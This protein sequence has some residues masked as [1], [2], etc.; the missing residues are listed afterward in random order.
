MH[1]VQLSGVA[2]NFA[3]REIFRDL[4]WEIGERDRVGLVG[5]NGSGKSSLLKVVAGVVEPDEGTVA[6]VGQVSVGYLPQDVHLPSGQSVIEAAMALPPELAALESALARVE[7]QLS[8]PAVY[9]DLGRLDQ[10]LVE[11]ERLLEEFEALGGQRHAGLVREV[12]HHLG[13][14][15]EDYDLP[16]D[17]LSGG[18]KKLVAL[19]KLAVEK[20]D[21][22][23]LDEPD[24]HLDLRAK[25]HLESFIRNYSGAVVIVSHDRYLLDEVVDRIA[26]LES[27]RLTVYPGN[28][29]TYATARELRLLRQQQLYVTQQKEV[30]RIEAMIKRFDHLA[31]VMDDERSA[32][33]ARSMR[34]R[35]DRMEA[36]GDLVDAVRERRDMKLELNGWRGSQKALEVKRLS[37]GFDDDL[38]F[39]DLDFLIQHGER[40]GLVGPN[41]RG[42]SVLMRL[43]LGELEPLDGE[44]VIGPSVRVGY[45]AQEHQTL[46]EWLDRTPLEFVRHVKVGREEDAI[47]FLIKFLFSYEQVRQPIRTLSGGE[48]SRLQL[49]RLML[50]QPNLL[51]MDEPTNNLDIPSAEVLES[52]LAGFDGAMLV[53]SHDRYFL[54]RVVDR[55]M[56]LDDGGVRNFEGSYS[57]WLEVTP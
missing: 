48:R 53:I 9:N 19:A 16:V 8:D 29:S 51:L 1:I 13:F 57:E 15:A 36:S 43:V 17:V 14:T 50:T 24:N 4:S 46:E 52:A 31:H 12:L 23:L 39:L 33:Q 45:Y 28:Y 40:V 42:K 25:R 38:L 56:V 22:L 18:Q 34:K 20:P 3:G 26:E 35:L 49:A 44:V 7:E 10:V 41:G 6:R 37:M 5:P 47:A 11:Q 30:A 55:V 27:G 2:V 54:D 32:R 21:V